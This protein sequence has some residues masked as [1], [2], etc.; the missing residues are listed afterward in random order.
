MTTV[1][2][3]ENIN[4]Q[5]YEQI[6]K[7][8]FIRLSNRNQ[9]VYPLVPHKV[10][11]DLVIT[12]YICLNL[13]ALTGSVSSIIKVSNGMLKRLGID[14]DTLHQDAV[15]NSQEIFPARYCAIEDY[16]G[17]LPAGET[18]ST[19]MVLTNQFMLY[20]ASA[21]FYPGVLDKIADSLQKNFFIFPSSVH[22]VIL[23]PDTGNYVIKELEQM[24][25]DINTNVVK[26][27]DRLS[28]HV[29]YFDADQHRFEKI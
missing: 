12:Y 1:K 17:G 21:M 18:P 24:V 6:K 14:A 26:P 5:D 29:Y 11:K 4:L 25:I 28:N 16:L 9:E 27:E 7:G 20:G 10:I 23:A 13:P 2:K 19:L 8:L 22:E 3:C 15:R